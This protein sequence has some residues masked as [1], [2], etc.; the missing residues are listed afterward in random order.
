MN[1]QTVI[2]ERIEVVHDLASPYPTDYLIV[3]QDAC[4]LDILNTVPSLTRTDGSLKSQ[5]PI[6]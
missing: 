3:A 6:H 1:V 2:L 4:C 5:P